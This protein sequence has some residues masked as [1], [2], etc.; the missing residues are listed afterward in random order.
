MTR[1]AGAGRSLVV[2]AGEGAPG[3]DR[4]GNRRREAAEGYA[5]I[6]RDL[7]DRASSWGADIPADARTIAL[8]RD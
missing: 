8:A 4:G 3:A 7:T 5:A 6:G 1:H 2:G